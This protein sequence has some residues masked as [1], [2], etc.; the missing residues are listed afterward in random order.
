VEGLLREYETTTILRPEIGE[1][2]IERVKGR[3]VGIVEKAE[4]KMLRI[5]NWGKRKLAYE[6]EKNTKGVYLYFLYLGPAG[7][8][9]E[10]ERN[11]KMWD[12]VMRF[13]T[14][15]VDEDVD[16]EARPADVTSDEL[17]AA[18]EAASKPAPETLPPDYSAYE[19]AMASTTEDGEPVEAAAE[20]A[21]EE[22]AEEPAEAAAEEAPE[23][24]AEEEEAPEEGAEEPAEAAAEEA[25]E[26]GAE[27]PAEAA[28]EE[29]ASEEAQAD[30]EDAEEQTEEPTA[31]ADDAEGEDKETD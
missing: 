10:V 7:V 14:V 4:G 25:P 8:V 2:N 13:L 11:C 15:K 6:V 24:A 23:A 19:E 9:Q 30:A 12:D 1:H 31:G 20:E 28:A 16:P 27:E 5:E 26:E 18:A 21:P 29:E 17:K 22:G 3:V